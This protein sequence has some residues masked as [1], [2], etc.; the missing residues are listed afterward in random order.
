MP[1]SDSSARLYEILRKGSESA[2]PRLLGCVLQYGRPDGRIMSGRI[3][4]VEAYA[5]TDPASHTYAGETARN[6]AMFKDAGTAYVYF[7]YGMYYCFNIVCGSPGVGQGVL[8]RA[9]EPMTGVELMWRNR[10]H[11]DMPL[12]PDSVKLHNLTSGPA[13]L[14]LALGISRLHDKH[15]LLDDRSEVR[16]SLGAPP[17]HIVQTTRIGITKAV[18][19]PW[20]WYDADSK[21]ISKRS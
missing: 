21:F 16:L 3:V 2:A 6:G 5:E 9:I 8:I 7:T 15:A 11:E 4:E 14:V 18:D 20:R 17:E 13:K 12:E 10:Y 19:V 1:I